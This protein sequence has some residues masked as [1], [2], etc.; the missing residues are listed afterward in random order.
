MIQN[1]AILLDG[2]EAIAHAARDL[3]V[4]LGSGYPGT[5]S[6]S[7]LET[8]SALGCA[9]RWSPNEKV[10]LEVG[11]GV[12]FGG[13]R[14]IVTMK[15]VGLNVAADPL[16]TAA[17]TGVS[18]G[19]VIIVADDPGMVY[20]QNEQDSRHYA[21]AMGIPMLEPADSQECYDYLVAAMTISERWGT[22]VLLRMTTRVSHTKTRVIPQKPAS[23]T[24]RPHFERDI[25]SRVMIPS[26]ALAA[27]DRLLSRLSAIATWA[28]QTE[29]NRTIEGSDSLGIITSGVATY[30]AMEAAPDASILKLGLAYPLPEERIRRFAASVERC[31]VVEEGDRVLA[32]ACRAAGAIV[33]SKPLANCVGELNVERVRRLVD[34]TSSKDE[35]TPTESSPPKTCQGCAYPAV[36]QVFKDLD[37]IVAGDIGCYTLAALPPHEA[38]DTV[39]CMGASIGVGLGLRHILP[40]DE[41]RRVVSV[42]GDST[43]LHSGIGGLIEMVYNRPQ[44]GHVVVILDNGT[45]AMTGLQEN[46]AT[47]RTLDHRATGRVIIEDV[48][49][50]IGVD[51]VSVVDPQEQPT[52]FKALLVQAMATDRLSVIVSRRPCLFCA[53]PQSETNGQP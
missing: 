19:F 6:T 7:I 27:H 29:L 11:L 5:P 28:E 8:F 40:P 21:R 18:S 30:H 1:Q 4:A 14:A 45:T 26:Y 31:L 17:Y 52:V 47:G 35:V 33:E 10:A 50:A 3:N 16:F 48:A 13:G 22:P 23:P 9:A 24:Q 44:R 37:C 25:R 39:V 34:G 51:D 42:I 36:F 46:P 49:R 53:P 2:N 43:F 41:A 38:I 15:H 20:S 12:A 32:D